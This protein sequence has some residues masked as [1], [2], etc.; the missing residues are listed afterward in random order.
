VKLKTYHA[1]SMAEALAAVKR[2]LGADAVIL[3]TRSFRRGGFLGIG[4][5]TVFEV[6]ATASAEAQAKSAPVPRADRVVRAYQS[7][8]GGREG[9][10]DDQGPTEMDRRKTQRLAQAMLEKHEREQ[11][12]LSATS[13]LSGADEPES[14]PEPRIE[15]RLE[16]TTETASAAA[17]A[18]AKEP[19]ARRFVL[20]DAGREDPPPN[21]RVAAAVAMTPETVAPAGEV[22]QD[23]LSAIR[24]MVTEVLQHQTRAASGVAPTLPQKLFDMYLTLIGQDVS[25]ELADRIVTA[26]RDE[27]DE[28]ALEDVEQVRAAALRCLAEYIPTAGE[29]VAS[30]THDGRPLT[31]AMVGPTGVGKT[32]TLA[33]IA[34]SFKLRH[35]CRVGLITADTYRIAAVEQLR[36]YG[37]I[38]GL[39]LRVVLTPAEM[40]QAV[41]AMRDRDVILIDTA[42]RS[43]ND[44]SRIDELRSFMEAAQP[45]EIHLVLSSTAGEKVLLREAEAFGVV[46]VDRLVL[47]KLDEA[48]SFGV[49]VNVMQQVGKALSFVTTG[50]EVPDHLEVGRSDRLARLVLGESAEEVHA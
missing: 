31:I 6:T 27:L 35:G 13:D 16:T 2:E 8:A 42:G 43:Q 10:D 4:R 28:P 17:E 5:R 1:Y 40:R 15:P 37:N 21:G 29:L 12:R 24:T 32:T 50:Q 14:P 38:I 25:E 20:Q 39:P 33:K 49:I 7:V 44:T 26:V 47:T 34:A 36:T 18:A 23:E 9:A 45:H 3:R 30:R 41:H 46:G 48:V 22:L 19:V 11:A